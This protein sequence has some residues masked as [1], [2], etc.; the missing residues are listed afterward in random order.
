MALRSINLLSFASHRTL[1]MMTAGM[2]ASALSFSQPAV[3]KSAAG[4][5]IQSYSCAFAGQ[6]RLFL[7]LNSGFFYPGEDLSFKAVLFDAGMQVKTDGSRFF[8]LQLTDDSFRNI[9]EYTFE[10]QSGECD[11]KIS[12]PDTLPTGIYSLK[13]F[14]RWMQCYHPGNAFRRPLMII[15]PLNGDKTGLAVQ[16]SLPVNFYPAGG[17]LLTG[18]G[19]EILVRVSPHSAMPVR[20]LNIVDDLDSTILSCYP[21]DNGIAVF[22]LT[23]EPGRKYYAFPA[24]TGRSRQIFE[25]PAQQSGGYGMSIKADRENIRILVASAGETDPGDELSLAILTGDEAKSPVYRVGMVNRRGTVVVPAGEMPQGLSQ[26]VLFNGHSVLCSRVW[27]RSREQQH[28]R[29]IFRLPDSVRT[30]EPVTAECLFAEADHA[31]KIFSAAVNEYNP[32]TD[33]LFYNEVSH[34]LF[35]D[36]YSSLL[37]YDLLPPFDRGTPEEY[38]NQCLIAVNST[39]PMDFVLHGKDRKGIVRETRGVILS[40]RVVSPVTR[41]PVKRATVLLSTPDSV[42]HIH[43]AMTNDLGEFSFTLNEKLYNRQLYLMA[44]GYPQATNPVAIVAD[45]PFRVPAPGMTTVSLAHPEV[46]KA[47]E[48]H[49]NIAIAY[50]VFYR[51]K[52]GPYLQDFRDH[53]SYTANF[54]GKPDF[55]LIPSEY[56]SLPDL[57]EIRKNLIPMLKLKV[58]DNYCSMRVF[59]DRLYLFPD[60]Q[61]LVLLNNIPF[62]SFKNVLELNSD[63]IRN[64]DIRQG[65]HYYDQYLMVGIVSINTTRPVTVEPYYSSLITSVRVERAGDASL[66]GQRMAEGSMPDVRHTLHWDTRFP[67]VDGTRDIRFRTSDIKGNYQFRVFTVAPGGSWHCDDK[68]ITVY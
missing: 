53:P 9:A 22:S 18:T 62:P 26:L 64:I 39:L 63:L 66:P 1:M 56:E 37:R 68:I 19:N 17:R 36:L 29:T 27:Y 30:R 20:Q 10:L 32:V 57:F 33:R 15:S 59:D 35:F 4:D 65:R 43:Y 46:E 48:N 47:I 67:C 45:D 42:S 41:E 51:S 2:L 5:A 3:R 49:K 40:G 14:T 54:Y 60:R 23:P 38:I 24:D 61:A 44:E 11:G 12:L 50:S 58:E 52:P 21:D 34:F 25:L 55:M 7:F 13:A 28:A 16:D 8:Y 31:L 6:E